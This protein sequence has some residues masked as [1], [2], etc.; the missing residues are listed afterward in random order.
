MR[1]GIKVYQWRRRVW[2]V[3][4]HILVAITCLITLSPFYW[5]VRTSLVPAEDLYGSYSLF[6]Q[7]VTFEHYQEVWNHTNF[8][9]NVQNS[10]EVL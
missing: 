4:K 1:G 10:L 6:P 2:W 7:R 9:R 3:S 8:P 5:M